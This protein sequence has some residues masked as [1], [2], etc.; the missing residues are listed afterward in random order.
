MGYNTGSHI[1]GSGFVHIPDFSV[2]ILIKVRINMKLFDYFNTDF[3]GR[4]LTFCI[5]TDTQYG[6]LQGKKYYDFIA[7]CTFFSFYVPQKLD[8]KFIIKLLEGFDGKHT[9]PVFTIQRK[10]S[11]PS[12]D[13]MA[14]DSIHFEQDEIK[15]KNLSESDLFYE[16]MSSLQFTGRIYFYLEHSLSESD[17]LE[18]VDYGKSLNARIKFRTNEYA[19]IRDTFKNPKAFISHDSKDKN[20][21]V[22]DIA[23]YLRGRLCPIW[24]DEYSLTPGD[25][26]VKQINIGLE[27]CPSC[28]MILSKN[29]IKNTS[30]ASAEF[31]AIV[32][33]QIS[34]NNKKIIPIW[35]DVTASEVREFNS[36]IAGKVAIQYDLNNPDASLQKIYDCI[37]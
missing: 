19:R 7:G 21:I 1:H 29:F 25:S 3:Q 26:L 32:N 27:K 17:I 14:G 34:T 9:Q 2:P 18:I 13:V 36:Y 23:N 11:L 31:E 6:S 37:N 24:Y 16:K 30:W 12:D 5:E 8:K 22:R 33:A 15:M 35:Y 28:L 4:C 10:I 20:N